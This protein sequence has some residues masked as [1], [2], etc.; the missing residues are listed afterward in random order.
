MDESF[1]ITVA[2]CSVL[3][4]GLLLWLLTRPAFRVR[5]TPMPVTVAHYAHVVVA[6]ALESKRRAGLRWKAAQGTFIVKRG[7]AGCAAVSPTLGATGAD[8]AAFELQVTGLQPGVDKV[9]VSATP[10]GRKGAIVVD[11][12]VTVTED[13]RGNRRIRHTAAVLSDPGRPDIR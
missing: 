1:L 13:E 11:V 9:R 7:A 5:I 8:G 12:P 3:G 4:G 10:R 2:G 6:V